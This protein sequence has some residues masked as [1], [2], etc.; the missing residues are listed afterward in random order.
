M[1]AGTEPVYRAEHSHHKDDSQVPA[2][3]EIGGAVM[4]SEKHAKYHTDVHGPTRL[5]VKY[6]MEKQTSCKCCT[7]VMVTAPSA[8]DGSNMHVDSSIHVGSNMQRQ[9][10]AKAVA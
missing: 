2:H 3:Q 1:L 5:R 4:C 7:P 8:S 10:H 9:Q 6:S